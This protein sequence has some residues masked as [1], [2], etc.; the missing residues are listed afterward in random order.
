MPASE[1]VLVL[2]TA[3]LAQTCSYGTCRAYLSA[4]RHWHVSR[5][6][7]DPLVNTQQL[8][9]TLRG[10]RRFKP[11]TPDSRLPITPLI[12]ETILRVVQ[13]NSTDY[14]NILM[15]A[16][17]C[18]GYFAFMRSGEFTVN[19]QFDHSRHLTVRDVAVDSYD[20]PSMLSIHLKTSKT[21]QEGVGVV[22]YVG[23]TFKPVCPVIVM[24]TYLVVRKQPRDEGPLFRCED[25]A[26]LSRPALVAWLRTTLESAGID[27][28]HFSGH[29]FRIGAAST[30]AS[31]G[32][33][34]STIQTLGRWSSDSF[35]RYIRIPRENLAQISQSIVT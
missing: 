8:T 26:P 13:Q 18:L 28:R 24:L 17:C 31:K 3:Y 4:V 2:F 7:P 9:L 35:K 23:R 10:I 12:L 19:E 29:S 20:S 30:A 1:Q 27:A 5:G 14:T 22:L 25:G 16:A 6:C 33:P 15:W 21:D 34:D 11:S 32:I